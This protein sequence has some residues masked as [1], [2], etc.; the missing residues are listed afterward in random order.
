MNDNRMN[1][2][3]FW[4]SVVLVVL[5]IEGCSNSSREEQ[6]GPRQNPEVAGAPM[7]VVGRITMSR[8]EAPVYLGG[9]V[10]LPN[11]LPPAGRLDVDL[12]KS[13]IEALTRTAVTVSDSGERLTIDGPE[14]EGY[15]IKRS[16]VFSIS[17]KE[18]THGLLPSHAANRQILGGPTNRSPGIVHNTEADMLDSARAL[19][20]ALG[21]LESEMDQSDVQR[22][23]AKDEGGQSEEVLRKVFIF[24]RI[25]GLEA[26]SQR[27]VVTFDRDGVFRAV[28]GRW[29]S[30]D[31]TKTRLSGALALDSKSFAQ[32]AERA[33]TEKHPRA[34]LDP[35]HARTRVIW[36]FEEHDTETVLSLK[37]Q[38]GLTI[39]GPNLDPRYTIFDFDI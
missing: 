26:P 25:V 27:S 33:T 11:R 3:L 35:D 5:T 10:A 21:A 30:Y 29:S 32:L 36:T 16:G 8:H 37:G 15:I 34:T 1:R 24:R 19:T 13:K 22:V 12:V 39:K 9:V 31:A 2:V 20:I 4:C 38:V 23:V 14:F 28:R 17:K 6:K 7:E 18:L